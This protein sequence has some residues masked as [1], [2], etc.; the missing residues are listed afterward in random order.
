M[1]FGHYSRQGAGSPLLI[2]SADYV[3]QGELA[4]LVSCVHELAEHT[5][6][7]VVMVQGLEIYPDGTL[8]LSHEHE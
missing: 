6:E 8:T 7:K 2:N 3:K 4:W 5:A 1:M